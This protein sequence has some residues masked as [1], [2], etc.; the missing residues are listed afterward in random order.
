ME[1]FASERMPISILLDAE[2]VAWLRAESARRAAAG[3][4][5]STLGAIVRAAI[6][7]LAKRDVNAE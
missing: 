5:V 1:D 4:D 7:M 6:R 3:S 2:S